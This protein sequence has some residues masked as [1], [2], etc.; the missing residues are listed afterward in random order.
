MNMEQLHAIKM[1]LA[2]LTSAV[3]DFDVDTD[4]QDDHI[5]M[6]HLH[7]IEAERYLS[8]LLYEVEQ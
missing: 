4:E 2:Y 3:N 5:D 1:Q 7:L 8:Y 6:V